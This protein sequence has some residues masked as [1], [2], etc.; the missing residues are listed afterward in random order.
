M[1]DTWQ[2]RYFHNYLDKVDLWTTTTQ[3]PLIFLSYRNYNAICCS[4][5]WESEGH[6]PYG[7]T[8]L[9]TILCLKSKKWE[10][11]RLSTSSNS[12]SAFTRLTHVID[13]PAG[14]GQGCASAGAEGQVSVSRWLHL[15]VA[16]FSALAGQ[17][18][19]ISDGGVR[20]LTIKGARA[21]A[22]HGGLYVIYTHYRRDIT[23]VFISH[24][25]LG[26]TKM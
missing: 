5:K 16:A 9:T 18:G 19:R 8:V 1:N 7:N 24:H 25:P 2:H 3:N 14:S 6:F 26:E 20:I 4:N 15:H 13:V 17:A 22:T 12:P 10:N 11:W 23:H 21:G